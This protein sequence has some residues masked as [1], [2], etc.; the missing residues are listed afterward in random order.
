L[1][2]NKAVTSSNSIETIKESPSTA[3][4]EG[5]RFMESTRVGT[6]SQVIPLQSV[7]SYSIGNMSFNRWKTYG[8]AD[9]MFENSH[10]TFSLLDALQQDSN[11]VQ[12]AVTSSKK[13]S[14]ELIISI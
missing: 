13:V 1:D 6:S 9:P 14:F 4:K 3:L 5:D 10:K 12:Y 7:A 2:V 11:E 8:S